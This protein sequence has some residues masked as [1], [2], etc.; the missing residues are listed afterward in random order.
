M[1]KGLKSRFV[2]E[3][4]YNM[5]GHLKAVEILTRFHDDYGEVKSFLEVHG[6]LSAEDKWLNFQLQLRSVQL[7]QD[8]IGQHQ[9]LVS[10]NIDADIAVRLM[11]SQS[12][13]K[14]LSEAPYIRLE[15]SE[16][17]PQCRFCDTSSPLHHL[18]AYTHLWL[19][20]VGSGSKN[21]FNCLTKGLF[22]AAKIDKTFFWKHQ[23]DGVEFLGKIIRDLTRFAGS[24]IVEGIEKPEQ[25]KLLASY[26][27][28]WLQGYLFESVDI[29]HFKKLPLYL[30]P[31]GD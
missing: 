21:N 18:R 4:V 23:H 19:D 28:C 27:Q 17:F 16:D 7:F 29:E 2:C 8:Y 13:L 25:V 30:E 1:L 12:F 31:F 24:V 15:V 3:P 5:Q 14:I 6:L 10:L 9:V 20:D 11:A 26:S 22:E